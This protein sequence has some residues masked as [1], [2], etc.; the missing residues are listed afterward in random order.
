ML[1]FSLAAVIFLFCILLTL[2]RLL[3]VPSS[4]SSPSFTFSAFLMNSLSFSFLL[5]ID[6]I[7]FLFF[8]F[9]CS[10][11][12][13]SMAFSSFFK[14]LGS[15]FP[16]ATLEVSFL[17]LLTMLLGPS[18]LLLPLLLLLHLLPFITYF[19]GR[20]HHVPLHGLPDGRPTETVAAGRRRPRQQ[21]VHDR[22]RD[23]RTANRHRRVQRQKRFQAGVRE[24]QALRGKS[25]ASVYVYVSRAVV[26]WHI[27]VEFCWRL[28][29]KNADDVCF[30]N[31]K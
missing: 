8:F 25:D 7:S 31:T 1:I 11:W 28:F 23:D 19:S 29:V 21:G 30:I 10:P 16:I 20:F 3:C 17:F 26:L 13:A 22:R 9:F 2:Q 24:Q 5:S 4:I 12:V 6:L 18:V 15:Y 14:V 27:R